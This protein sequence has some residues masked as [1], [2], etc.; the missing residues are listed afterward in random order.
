[1]VENGRS[2]RVRACF[3]ERKVSDVSALIR[4][5]L[6]KNSPVFGSMMMPSLTLA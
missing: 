6:M 4:K 5:H 1:M 3:C 2:H